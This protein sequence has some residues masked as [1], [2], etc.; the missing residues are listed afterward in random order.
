MRYLLL[1]FLLLAGSANATFI[2]V[3]ADDFLPGE[4]VTAI[5][6]SISASGYGETSPVYAAYD[7]D[8]AVSGDNV[9]VGDIFGGAWFDPSGCSPS[10]SAPEPCTRSGSYNALVLRF[11][12]PTNHV[13]ASGVWNVDSLSVWAFSEDGRHLG[14]GFGDPVVCLGLDGEPCSGSASV[15]TDHES[16]SLAAIGGWGTWSSVDSVAYS[17]PE[18]ESIFLMA[19]GLLALFLRRKRSTGV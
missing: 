10:L 19:V 12:D 1:G 8:R 4:V 11:D 13:E 7:P 15:T 6:A 9:F 16:I 3:D 17:V 18:P 5:E 2:I 14:I